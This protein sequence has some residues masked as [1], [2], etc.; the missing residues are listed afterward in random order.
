LYDVAILHADQQI[1]LK[2]HRKRRIYDQF[3]S[4]INDIPKIVINHGTPVL[5]EA[6][7]ELEMTEEEMQSECIRQ[8]RQLIG[9]N[10]MVVN[11]HTSASEKE[12]GFGIP[13]V[14]GIRHDDWRDL[15][16]EP[17][18]FTAL[19]SFGLDEYYNRQCMLE[20]AEELFDVYG[21]KLWYAKVNVS[22]H[23]SIESYK[24]YL[25]RSLL[26]LDT[27]FRTP[28]NRG[29]TEAFLSGCC[30]IQVEGAHDLHRWAEPNKN[31]VVV[32]ND[33]KEIARVI[34]NFLEKDY[35]QALEI[36]KRGREMAIKAFNPERY[37]QDWVGLL[38][39]VINY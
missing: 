29:R 6:F 2:D 32:P 27:S 20:T 13:I 25:G 23:L 7:S 35:G 22:T 28:M 36:G 11:S 1:I 21:Y 8:V 39:K 4:L 12:W 34:V 31:I 10:I 26:Y 24:D 30:V 5:P 19:S 9:E 33:P 38:E 18:V 16:K 15:P 37:R 14:H 3:N 17:R